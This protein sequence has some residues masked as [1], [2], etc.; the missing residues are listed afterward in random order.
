VRKPLPFGEL[1]QP[2]RL[3]R[4]ARPDD[5]EPD[6]LPLLQ[7]LPPL[8]EGGEQEVGERAVLEEQLLQHFPLDRDV[9]H[10]LGD[11]GGEED[12]LP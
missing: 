7:H 8:D 10:R 2:P 9:A 1:D 3:R 6:P 12:R 4:L 5:L 11:D